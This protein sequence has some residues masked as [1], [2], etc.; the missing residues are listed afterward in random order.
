MRRLLMGASTRDLPGTKPAHPFEKGDLC[1]APPPADL[2]STYADKDMYLAIV[3]H[4]SP[5]QVIFFGDGS[6][7]IHVVAKL[8]PAPLQEREAAKERYLAA[9]HEAKRLAGEDSEAIIATAIEEVSQ[10]KGGTLGARHLVI[11]LHAS[12][13]R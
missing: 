2:R 10:K 3:H 9:L 7:T 4:H 6:E 11:H 5:P 13:L 8:V 12:R 1:L